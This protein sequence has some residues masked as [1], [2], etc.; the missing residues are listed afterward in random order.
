MCVCDDV[1]RQSTQVW[2]KDIKLTLIFCRPSENTF[3]SP[4]FKYFYNIF[5]FPFFF[6]FIFEKLFLK[7]QEVHVCGSNLSLYLNFMKR[8]LFSLPYQMTCLSVH[9]ISMIIFKRIKVY[10]G[11]FYTSMVS[12]TYNNMQYNRHERTCITRKPFYYLNYPS[13]VYSTVVFF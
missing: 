12:L 13:N 6:F 11:L 2:F 1:T 7:T 8:T 3:S 10:F 5:F 9:S 4:G